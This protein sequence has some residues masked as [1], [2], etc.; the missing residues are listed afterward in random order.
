M[1]AFNVL[2]PN[3]F[4][5]GLDFHDALIPPDPKPIPFMPHSVFAP[6]EG[7]FGVG[8]VKKAAKT[9]AEYVPMLQRGTDIGQGI[10]H[11]GLNA[12][13]PFVIAGSGSKSYFGAGTVKL[14][15]TATAVAV[16]HDANINLNCGGSTGPPTPTGYVFAPCTV[17]AGMTFGDLLAGILQ[18][19]VEAAVQWGI[20]FALGKVL[21]NVLAPVIKAIG[22]WFGALLSNTVGTLIGWAIGTPL[23]YSFGGG[24]LGP[25]YSQFD[26]GHD[27]VADYFNNP[28]RR[29]FL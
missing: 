1:S 17:R 24:L 18:M 14:E 22:P 12:L 2:K 6:L 19:V 26:K 23:G 21:D 7:Y 11:I 25:V 5:L 29:A 20:G 3:H 27:A 10:P 15:G 9:S 4:M 28:K 8:S 16:L 13:L